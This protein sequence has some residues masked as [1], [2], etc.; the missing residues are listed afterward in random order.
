MHAD[1]AIS[2]DSGVLL[3]A[4]PTEALS[5][6]SYS[7]YRKLFNAAIRSVVRGGSAAL[8]CDWGQLKQ[9]LLKQVQ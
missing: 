7:V 6:R 1:D 8:D 2:R 4:H 3:P 5:P 9:L